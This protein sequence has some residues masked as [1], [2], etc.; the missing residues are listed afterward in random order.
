MQIKLELSYAYECLEF[1]YQTF[2][3]L[4]ESTSKFGRL[5]TAIKRD[6]CLYRID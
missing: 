2:G 6:D 4:G 5:Q 3:L 1:C